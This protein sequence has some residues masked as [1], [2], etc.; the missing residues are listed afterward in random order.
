[1]IKKY[2]GFILEKLKFVVLSLL[3]SNIY[4]TTEFLM[5]LKTLTNQTGSVGQIAAQILSVIED[6]RW[7]SQDK[8]KQNYFDLVD[9]EDT[10]GFINNIKLK[11]LSDELNLNPNLPYEIPGRG[12]IK[13]G[14]IV[15]YIC[16]LLGTN[17]NDADRE[18]FVNAWKSSTNAPSIVFKLVSGADIAKYYNKKNY[19]KNSGSLGNSC[20]SDESKGIF[21]IYTENTDKV[22]LLVYLDEDEKVHGRALVWKLKKSPCESKYFMDRVYTNRDSDVN[23]FKEF[24]NNEGWFYKKIITSY[25][26]HNV[27]F[28][29]KGND[30]SGELK[31]KLEGDLQKYPYLDTMFYLSKDKDSLSN[32]SDKNCFLLRSVWGDRERCS[33]CHGD[34]I[35]EN[36]SGAEKLCDG[37]SSGHQYLKD[38]GIETKW[39]KKI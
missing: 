33:D 39:N 31:L 15:N 34:I 36:W 21:K 20:M 28:V 38:L 12:E 18:A 22:K 2:D 35:V 6:E 1:M 16:S 26:N 9:S 5:K 17:I 29:Y 10:V 24:A 32:L 14:K 30:I 19:Y 27:D 11:D 4:A 13:I 8:I 23:R 25:D 3:E 7:I 37:C